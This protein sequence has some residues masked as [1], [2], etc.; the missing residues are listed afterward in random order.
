MLQC[1]PKSKNVVHVVVVCI[2]L[3]TKIK[4]LENIYCIMDMYKLQVWNEEI[5]KGLH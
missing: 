2:Y 3:L 4:Y 5:I 1:Y